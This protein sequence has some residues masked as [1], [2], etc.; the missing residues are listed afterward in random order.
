MLL[1]GNPRAG[2]GLYMSIPLGF[3]NRA[4]D[5]LFTFNDQFVIVVEIVNDE[6]FLEYYRRT[7]N[8]GYLLMYED[9]D[10][11]K[12]VITESRKDE[13]I[14]LCIRGFVDVLRFLGREPLQ[15]D[16][17]LYLRIKEAVEEEKNAVPT[18]ERR[19][20]PKSPPELVIRRPE[21]SGVPVTF[22]S[23]IIKVSSI[24][25]KYNGGINKF[26]KDTTSSSP[27]GEMWR[28]GYDGRLLSRSAMAQDDLDDTIAQLLEHGFQC[29]TS[30]ADFY[31][32]LVDWGMSEPGG[33]LMANCFTFDDDQIEYF[34]EKGTFFA[35]LKSGEA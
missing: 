12:I 16:E 29:K 9:K 31:V 18:L 15:S 28:W 8:V 27:G 26:I 17:E 2:T 14:D 13:F 1:K 20:T 24:N 35:R 23:L 3:I 21:G 10:T 19:E 34:E 5:R 22:F 6:E 30:P 33:R 25:M 7:K 32:T 11:P 4:V